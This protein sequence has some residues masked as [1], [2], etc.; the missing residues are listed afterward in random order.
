M[1]APAA[2]LRVGRAAWPPPGLRRPPQRGLARDRYL[3]RAPAAGGGVDRTGARRRA[4]DR[5]R[6]RGR[7]STAGGGR[8]SADVKVP[9]LAESISEATLVEWLKPDGA[10]VR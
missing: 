4:G 9:R 8:V 5:E 2:S 10:P 1:A 6:R 3:R 7:G